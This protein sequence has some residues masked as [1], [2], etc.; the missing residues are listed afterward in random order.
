MDIKEKLLALQVIL[1]DIRGNWGYDL[2]ERVDKAEELVD[3]IMSDDKHSEDMEYMKESIN[4]FRDN[5]KEGYADGRS[6]R[7]EYPCGYENM[8]EIHG[9]SKTYQD[10][11]DEFKV[12]V[13]CLTYPENRF[14][15]IE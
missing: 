3:S 10:K 11:S 4:G 14:E 13:S 2:E 7:C 15:D 8:G 5:M 12:C 9:L 1:E 6:F